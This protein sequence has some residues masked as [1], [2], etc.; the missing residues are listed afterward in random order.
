[1]DPITLSLSLDDQHSEP[2]STGKE[3]GDDEKVAGLGQQGH[4]AR[5]T[6]RIEVPG[7]LHSARVEGSVDDAI[8]AGSGG[9]RRVGN[10]ARS[11]QSEVP[12]T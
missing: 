4:E 7:Q 3:Q 6:G 8:D 5:V 9:R 12:F 2:E 10:P 1:M 11:E